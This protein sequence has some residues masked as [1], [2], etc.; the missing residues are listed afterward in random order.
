MTEFEKFK[1]EVDTWIKD[2]KQ[3][4]DGLGQHSEQVKYN[5]GSIDD[6]E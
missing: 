5:S 4:V 6:L 1:K 2:L 3:Q